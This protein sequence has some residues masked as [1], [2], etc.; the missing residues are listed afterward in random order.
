MP[1]RQD[2][3]RIGVLLPFSNTAQETEFNR[4][5]PAGHLRPMPGNSFYS[6][7]HCETMQ[8]AV[9]VTP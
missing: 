5:V 6:G 8:G 7:Q 9:P 3:L 4:I 2:Q 1:A